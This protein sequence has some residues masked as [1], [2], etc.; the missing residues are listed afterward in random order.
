MNS[1]DIQ[2]KNREDLE[3][4]IDDYIQGIEKICAVT[5]DRDKNLAQQ[6]NIFLDRLCSLYKE[7]EAKEIAPILRAMK[8]RKY[9]FPKEYYTNPVRLKFENITVPVPRE[10][11][12]IL[13][14]Y[15]GDYNKICLLY[16][17]PS[18]RD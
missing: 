3:Q 2:G 9:R 18:P 8:D 16:T 10:Y 11:D 13:T 7:S 6:M 12:K 5:I 15:Y 1:N 17:S 14:T 4:E